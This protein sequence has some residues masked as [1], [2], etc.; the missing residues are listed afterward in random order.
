ML[1][2]RRRGFTLIEFMVM[3]AVLG[4]LLAFGLPQYSIWMQNLRIRSATESV[5][6]GLQMARAVAISRNTTAH[7]VFAAAPNSLSYFVLTVP[8]P[9]NPPADFQDPD[10]S[11]GTADIIRRHNQADD[12]ATANVLMTPADAYMVTFSALGQVVA[13]PDGS[14]QLQQV[15]IASATSTNPAIRPLRIVINPGGSTRACDPSAALA[16]DDPRRC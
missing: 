9:G 2:S 15:D 14:T 8:V 6:N 7:L 13:N 1:S 12:S 10:A 11:P 16:P 3:F 4:I 5:Q